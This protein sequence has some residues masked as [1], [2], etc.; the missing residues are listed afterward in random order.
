M[1]LSPYCQNQAHA[2]NVM[3]HRIFAW[4]ASEMITIINV[5]KKKYPAYIRISRHT[6]PI[7]HRHR[8]RFCL[9]VT[10]VVHAQSTCIT[11]IVYRD[12]HEIGELYLSYDG[13]FTPNF[14]LCKML[15]RSDR[16]K[17]AFAQR[18]TKRI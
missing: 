18:L 9:Y 13:N 15:S 3:F 2:H 16:S 14:A 5:Q 17:F 4:R 11:S 1:I 12:N 8:T 10:C 6:F 7:G